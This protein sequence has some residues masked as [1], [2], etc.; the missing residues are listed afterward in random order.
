MEM[1]GSKQGVADGFAVTGWSCL[2]LEST[3]TA[4]QFEKQ[5]SVEG[6]G[7]S[8]GCCW[9]VAVVERPPCCFSVPRCEDLAEANTVLQEHLD[10]ANLANSALQEDVGKLAAD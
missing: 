1:E 3:F 10:Q 2:I 4:S 8:R 9:W 7:K 5:V 6:V